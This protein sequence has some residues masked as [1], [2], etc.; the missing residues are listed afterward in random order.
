MRAANTKH[1]VESAAKHG[2]KDGGGVFHSFVKAS[3][4]VGVVVP[5]ILRKRMAEAGLTVESEKRK[6]GYHV[7]VFGPLKAM[8]EQGHQAAIDLYECE[9]R[10][11]KAGKPASDMPVLIAQGY[12]ATEEDALLHAIHAEM[13]AEKPETAG[14]AP[15]GEI[16]TRGESDDGSSRQR[17]GTGRPAK[18]GRGSRPR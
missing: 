14:T 15:A 12:A 18:Q 4:E 3:S 8:L 16:T 7:R 6:H 5:S 2:G 11:P 17:T 13:K 1:M 9:T 10:D